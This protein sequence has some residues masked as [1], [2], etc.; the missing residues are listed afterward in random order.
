MK[1]NNSYK[2]SMKRVEYLEKLK[3]GRT[4]CLVRDETIE[5][6]V[7]KSFSLMM[8]QVKCL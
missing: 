1:S 6:L 4:L 2:A 7:R 3:A 8:L 5:A